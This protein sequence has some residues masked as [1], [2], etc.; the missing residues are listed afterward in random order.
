[1]KLNKGYTLMHEHMA[2]DLSNIKQD[3][4]TQ[5]DCVEDIIE[6]IKELATLGVGNILEVTNMGMGRSI[7]VIE[8][9]EKETG[10][11]ILASTGF[12]KEPFLPENVEKLSIEDLALMMVKECNESIDGSHKKAVCIGEIGTSL[13]EMTSLEKKVFDAAILAAK[14]T[15]AILSTHTSLGTCAFK[16]AHYLISQGI[17]PKRIIIGHMDL[18]DNLNQVKEVLDLGVTIGFDTIGKNKYRPDTKRVEDLLVLENEGYLDQVVLSMDLTRKS[19]LKKNGGLGYSY[20]F[21]VFLPMLREK[22]MKEES[23][24]KMLV[25]NPNRLFNQVEDKK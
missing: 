2:V 9:V 20:L 15:T 7:E 17:D 23:I 18:L 10:I 13:D 14:S 8:K 11:Q 24:H 25:D 19:H 1:M 12:Y 3:K 21:K 4:D 5:Y 16:Q 22:G 6:E